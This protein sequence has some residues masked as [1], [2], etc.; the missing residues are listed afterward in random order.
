MRRTKI[1][2]TLGPA[3]REEEPLA[4]ILEAGVDVVRISFS[5]A[6]AEEAASVAE[7]ARRLAQEKG[8]YVGVLLDLQGPKIRVGKVGGSGKIE[9][10]PGQE[11]ILDPEIEEGDAQGVGLDYHDLYRDV[12]PGDT[13]LLD[14]GRISLFVIEVRGRAIATRVLNGGLLSSHKGINR[15]GGGLSAPAL[16]D[17]DLLDIET[18]ARIGPD[19][20]AVSFVREGADLDRVR[21]LLRIHGAV[22]QIVAKIERVEAVS[23]IEDILRACDALMVARGDLGVEIGFAKVPAIQKQLIRQAL[24][25]KKAVITATQ[26]METMITEPIPTRAEVSD[27]ANAVLDGTDAVMLSGETAVG[28]HPV[29]VVQA[30][31]QVCEDVEREA[32]AL[33]EDSEDTPF[34]VDGVEDAI[35]LTTQFTARNLPVKAIAALTLSGRTAFLMTRIHTRA[36]IFALTPS[37]RSCGRLS[38]IRGVYPIKFAHS[39]PEP[40]ALWS[41]AQKVLLQKGAVEEQDLAIFTIGEPIGRVGKTNTMKIIQVRTEKEAD[42]QAMGEVL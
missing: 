8:K 40:D 16:T 28:R 22:S 2:A 7:R 33:L 24:A 39:P 27:V 42:G 41:R 23:N 37:E 12:H 30:M 31:A 21:D 26:M 20:L 4:A 1:V 29:A 5:H 38:L 11:F 14:D 15:L 18:A 36:P 19:Y 13:L 10:Q 9:L 25:A 17:K 6:S 32:A 35:A 34:A 3:S